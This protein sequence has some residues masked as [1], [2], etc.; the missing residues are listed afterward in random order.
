MCGPQAKTIKVPLSFLG[1]GKYKTLLVRD[2]TNDDTALTV[3]NDTRER[4]DTINLELK[5]GGGF[6]GRF[7]KLK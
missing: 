4:R 1:E 3:E 6:I 7:S 5:P 2:A